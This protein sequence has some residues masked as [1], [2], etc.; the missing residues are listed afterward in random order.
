MPGQHGDFTD[1]AAQPVGVSHF[2]RRSLEGARER[3][4]DLCLLEA[5]AKLAAEQLREVPRL[6]R[7][8]R[9]ERIS[10]HIV[11]GGRT[12]GGSQSGEPTLHPL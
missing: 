5:D 1:V 12:G 7:A 8:Q 2:L 10:Q 6:T 3:L 4:L 9:R 11:S